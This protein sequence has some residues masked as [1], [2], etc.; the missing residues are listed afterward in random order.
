[1]LDAIHSWRR[2]L[3]GERLGASRRSATFAGA[4]APRTDFQR[5][6]DR[7]VF[8][9]AFRRLHDKTQVFP[10]PDND[11]VHSRL[12]HSLEVSCVGRSLGTMVGTHLMQRH[13]EL[14]Q[15]G[16]SARSFGDI[17]AAACL[18][19]DI[20]NPPFGH[21]GEDAIGSWFKAHPE[22]TQDLPPKQRLDLEHFEGNA[23]GLRILTRLQIPKNPGLQLTLAT[24]AAFTKYPREAGPRP[25][26]SNASTK[27]HGLFQSELGM[28]QAVAEGTGLHHGV[29]IAPAKQGGF[30]Y[31]GWSRHP[32]AFLMEAADDICYSILDIE[33][34]FRL[35]LVDFADAF[36]KLEHIAAQGTHY[37]VKTKATAPDDRK[38]QISHLRAQAINLL[39]HE[40]QDAFLD[41]ETELLA[42]KTKVALSEQIRASAALEEIAQ[43]TMQ[44]CYRSQ[45]VLQI[46][47]AGYKVLHHLLDELVPAVLTDTRT[48]EQKKLVT[49]VPVAPPPE[50]S[51]YE[52]LLRVTDYLSG[53][54]DSYAVGLF[55]RLTGMSL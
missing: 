14:V 53:M 25:T 26:P 49:V 36:D 50:A 23:Q 7:I 4:D 18:A 35:G 34:G 16:I 42:G 19:H 52:R 12:T 37:R 54:T 55:H 22:Y 9:T 5:D 41:Q 29:H 47:L 28:F 13:P 31:Q 32:L 46:E 33:D 6:F 44:A 11:L 48:M 17:V 38:E 40:V 20:G 30:T 8:S 43:F 21:A 51:P 24:L 45:G 15:S 1:M 3:S 2:L 39:A 27:K 10:L